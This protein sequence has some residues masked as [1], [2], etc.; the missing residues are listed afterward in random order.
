MTGELK[1]TEAIPGMLRPRSRAP[2]HQASQ[3]PSAATQQGFS[4]EEEGTS[5]SLVPQPGPS[6]SSLKNQRL[7]TD[8]SVLASSSSLPHAEIT[9]QGKT[10]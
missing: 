3:R 1:E 6:F 9:K 2:G 8:R 7:K 10:N 5:I 4:K